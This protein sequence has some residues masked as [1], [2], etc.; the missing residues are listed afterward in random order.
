MVATPISPIVLAQTPNFFLNFLFMIAVSFLEGGLTFANILT[1]TSTT[2]SKVDHKTAST[3]QIL[4][5]LISS[6]RIGTF[7]G[8]PLL[9]NGTGNPAFSAFSAPR[10]FLTGFGGFLLSYNSFE[11]LRLPKKYLYVLSKGF[12]LLIFD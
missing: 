3:V 10:V 5:D 4:S 6:A 12:C 1:P 2:S 11:V 9:D 7:E 8:D